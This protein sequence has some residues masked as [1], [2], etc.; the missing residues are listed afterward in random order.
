[1]FG[2]LFRPRLDGKSHGGTFTAHCGANHTQIEVQPG[3]K[4]GARALDAMSKL[5]S[6][7]PQRSIHGVFTTRSGET[8]L[9][10]SAIPDPEKQG[11]YRGNIRGRGYDGTETKVAFQDAHWPATTGH[12]ATHGKWIAHS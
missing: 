11:S 2:K 5:A 1:M 10:I 8:T 3:D 7:D 9:E 6:R 12:D 4:W